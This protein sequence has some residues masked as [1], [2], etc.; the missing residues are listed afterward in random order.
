[1]GK[2][3][4]GGGEFEHG[5]QRGGVSKLKPKTKPKKLS[6]QRPRGKW[7]YLPL[8][9]D[10]IEYSTHMYIYNPVSSAHN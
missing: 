6:W 9:S 3:A 4:G 1:M 2:K 5:T 7:Y 8:R 10:Y